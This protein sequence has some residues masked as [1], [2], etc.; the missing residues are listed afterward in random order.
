MAEEIILHQYC[1]LVPKQMKIGMLFVLIAYGV[2]PIGLA[3]AQTATGNGIKSDNIYEKQCFAIQGQARSQTLSP[4]TFDH[5]IV[6]KNKCF[7][8]IKLRVC[9]HQSDRCVTIITPPRS[10]KETWLGSFPSLRF[11]EYDAK[12]IPGLY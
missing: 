12:E 8:P 10:V 11:F 5:V 3:T 4:S 9:Y 6:V 2:L 1:A 7:K